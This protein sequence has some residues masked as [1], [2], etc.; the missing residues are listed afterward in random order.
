VAPGLMQTASIRH[1]HC[2]RVVP[3][4]AP[5]GAPWL[6]AD[7][8]AVASVRAYSAHTGQLTCE[9]KSLA[10]SLE[11]SSTCPTAPLCQHE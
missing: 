9:W 7:A 8:G 6:K 3:C 2:C 11:V 1:V 5:R 10:G 4:D